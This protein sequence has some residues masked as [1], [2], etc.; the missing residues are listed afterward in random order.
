MMV[1]ARPSALTL[2]QALFGENRKDARHCNLQARDIGITVI[3]VT[4]KLGGRKP[5]CT[6]MFSTGIY[7][8][9][10]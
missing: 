4:G 6:R 3:H 8:D 5:R 1:V 7:V 9:R 2:I 10:L